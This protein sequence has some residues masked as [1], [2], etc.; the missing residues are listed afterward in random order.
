MA[1]KE[2]KQFGQIKTEPVDGLTPT[3]EDMETIRD[4]YDHQIMVCIYFGKDENG[5]PAFGYTSTGETEGQKQA[6]AT[7]GRQIQDFLLEH[8]EKFMK[9]KTGK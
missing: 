7:L 8:F 5:A 4:K 3:E 9:G 6:G 1:K 2:D